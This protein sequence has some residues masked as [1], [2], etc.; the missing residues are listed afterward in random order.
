MNLKDY[1]SQIKELIL[2]HTDPDFNS[3]FDKILFGESNSDK[4]LVKMEL[5]RLTTPCQRI[6]DFRDKTLDPCIAFQLNNVEHHL[7]E[8]AIKV[9][10]KSID[11]YGSYTIGV[12][13]DVHFYLTQF[14]EDKNKKLLQKSKLKFDNH[15]PYVELSPKKRRANP[16][17]FFVSK[18]EIEL[19]DGLLY[20]CKTSNISSSGIK[21]RVKNNISVNDQDNIAVLF[22][23]LRSEFHEPALDNRII[24]KVVN[25]SIENEH[26]FIYLTY[27]DTKARFID[28]IS[29]FIHKNNYKYKIDAAYYYQIAQTDMLKNLYLAQMNSLPIYLNSRST[30]PFLFTLK[31]NSNQSILSAW[32]CKGVNQLTNLFTEKRLTELLAYARPEAFTI[33]YSFIYNSNGKDYFLSATEDELLKTGLKDIFIAYGSSKTNWNAYHLTITSY[34]YK[35]STNPERLMKKTPDEFLSITHVATLQKLIVDHSHVTIN[36]KE[37]KQLNEIKQFI[38]RP[39]NNQK[40]VVYELFSSEKRTEDRYLY[41]SELSLS[42]NNVD[43]KAQLIDFSESGLQIKL[44]YK[45]SI[46]LSSLVKID[47]IA[48]QKVS[49]KFPLT[50]L[51]YKVVLIKDKQTLHLQVADHATYNVC[52]QFFSLLV[53]RN[54]TS[55]KCIELKHTKQPTNELLVK[56]AENAFIGA[57]FFVGKSANKPKIQLSAIAELEHSLFTLFSM[58]SHKSDELNYQPI[59][60][61]HLYERLITSP[62]K[63]MLNGKMYHEAFIYVEAHRNRDNKWIIN[64]YLDK[65]FTTHEEKIAFIAQSHENSVFYALFYRISSFDPINKEEMQEQLKKIPSVSTYLQKNLEDDLFNIDAM[66][67]IVD[68]TSDILKTI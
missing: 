44:D 41:N 58:Q 27:A 25:Q 15:C 64:S 56:V 63:N 22:S 35:K 60:N 36:S 30:S 26:F 21:I 61:N 23:E 45:L 5:N 52:S 57:L 59:V 31:N 51:A 10:Q 3:L 68:M 1:Q 13:E 37:A 7:T 67:E 48:L 43:Y 34:H 19:P 39:N 65:D 38:H 6:I 9:L 33:I 47:L 12:F 8:E 62:Y 54:S 28:F 66:I 55:F 50:N 40:L 32:D 53:E 11:I 42:I 17:M 20:Q 24:Y 2:L 49:K 16:R 46:P 4:F 14:K 18:I 29:T